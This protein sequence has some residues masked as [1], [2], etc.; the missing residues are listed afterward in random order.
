METIMAVIVGLALSATA[1]FRVFTPLLITGLFVRTEWVTL[2]EGFEWIGSTPALVAFAVAT[3]LEI[4]VNYLPVIGTFLKMLA[5][6]AATIAGVLLTASFIGDM[7]PFLTWSIAIIGGGGLA[8]AAHATTTVVKGVSETAAVSPIV[9]AIEDGLAIIGPVL[10]FLV[11]ILAVAVLA[12]ALYLI[13]K[14]YRRVTLKDR[15]V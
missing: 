15:P 8:T 2:A 3:L 10:I 13:Y 14:A 4:G 11:P 9:S 1:G 12:V 6:P 7:D 5:A